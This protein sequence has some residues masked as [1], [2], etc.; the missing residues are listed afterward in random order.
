MQVLIQQVWL[1]PEMLPFLTGSQGMVMLPLQGPPL[2]RKVV[3][4]AESLD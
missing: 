2:D 3:N 1:A 4:H